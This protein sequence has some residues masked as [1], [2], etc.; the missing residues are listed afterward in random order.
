VLT[1]GLFGLAQPAH[2]AAGDSVECYNG[3]YSG[4]KIECIADVTGSQITWTFNG[5]HLAAYDGKT[6]MF[7]NCGT[8]G[9][10]YHVTVNYIDSTTGAPAEV[11]TYNT[12]GTPN[13]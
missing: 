4:Y 10:P 7:A 11:D 12:C 8:Y 3:N 2:A 13:P 9:S 1:A 5:S 6:I